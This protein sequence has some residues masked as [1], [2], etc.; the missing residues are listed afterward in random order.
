MSD[1]IFTHLNPGTSD[2]S[3]VI[4]AR[5]RLHPEEFPEQ[6]LLGLNSHECLA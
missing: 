5:L 3:R 1:G 4:G 6:D 2:Y